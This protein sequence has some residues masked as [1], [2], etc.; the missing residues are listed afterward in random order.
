MKSHTSVPLLPRTSQTDVLNCVELRTSPTH[1]TFLKAI[2]MHQFN[3]YA[4][5]YILYT[6]TE[7]HRT[8][9]QKKRSLCITYHY[10]RVGTQDRLYKQLLI[11]NRED[12]PLCVVPAALCTCSVGVQ[13]GVLTFEDF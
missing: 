10:G 7:A 5:V 4:T 1:S 6:L 8:L 9:Q 2:Q 13:S 12:S 3:Y 11:C